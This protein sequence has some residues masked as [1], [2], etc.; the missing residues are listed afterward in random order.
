MTPHLV[1]GQTRQD[2]LNLS[3]RPMRGWLMTSQVSSPWCFRFQKKQGFQIIYLLLGLW[4]F[5]FYD[6]FYLE[7]C[8]IFN[9][10][11]YKIRP[12]SVQLMWAHGS[13]DPWP[14]FWGQTRRDALNLSSRPMRGRWM[15]SQVSSLVFSF[16]RSRASNCL[17]TARLW[18]FSFLITFIRTLRYI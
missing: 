14:R 3:S 10:F 7:L 6:N 2:A 9:L 13:Y 4:G 16:A 8:V 12:S 1:W 5:S 11:F 17:F 15:T 18:G